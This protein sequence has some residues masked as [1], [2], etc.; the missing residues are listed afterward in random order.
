MRTIQKLGIILFFCCV[1]NVWAE[2]LRPAITTSIPLADLEKYPDYPRVI[3]KLILSATELSQEKLTYLYGSANPKNKGMDCSGTIHYLL[4]NANVTDVPRSAEEMFLWAEKKGNLYR[5][6]DKVF[7][8]PE[9]S[10]L[11]PGDLLFWSGTYPTK[12]NISHVMIY[13]G[14]NKKGQPLMFGSSN[15]RT[16]QH[17]KMWGV[18]VFDFQ[19]SNDK[20]NARFIGY[21]CIPDLTCHIKPSLGCN[22]EE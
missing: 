3:Q 11:K 14:K 15:G 2:D 7:D 18:S 5:I 1:K 9:F 16:Y 13:L 12:S 4:K 22:I 21:S 8:S 6:S 20:S 10:H 17:K 19:L